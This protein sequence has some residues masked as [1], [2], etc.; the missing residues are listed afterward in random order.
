MSVTDRV[1]DK[2]APIIQRAK[3]ENL[4]LEILG[5]GWQFKRNDEYVWHQ[6][7]AE[8]MCISATE[9]LQLCRVQDCLVLKGSTEHRI[10]AEN[11]VEIR[12]YIPEKLV[13]GAVLRDALILNPCLEIFASTRM[14]TPVEPSKV[15]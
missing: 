7:W 11:I 10:L 3:A 2:L 6:R 13:D 14:L 15:E 5:F 4:E 8:T 9:V 1:F 12:A